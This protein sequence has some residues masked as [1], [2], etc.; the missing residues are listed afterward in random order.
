M[1]IDKVMKLSVFFKLKKNF[2]KLLFNVDKLFYL[3]HEILLTTK[4]NE[5][6]NIYHDSIRGKKCIEELSLNIG[7]WAGNYSFFYVLNRVLYDYKPKRIIELGLGESTKFISTYLDNYL[8]ESEHHIVEHDKEWVDFFNFNFPLSNKS[9]I[10]NCPIITK[11]IKGYQSH[12]YDDLETVIIGKYD[13]Y[14]V[15]GPFGSE[16]YSRYNII[17][18]VKTFVDGDDFIILMD[19]TN[20]KGENDTKNDII[21]I[22]KDKKINFYTGDYSG[23]KCVTVISSEKYRFSTTM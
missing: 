11:D 10:I 14:I 15:D 17:S 2:V 5:W 8:L 16:R 6:A 18:F 22:L 12:Y 7:R 13:L 4:E 19:D 9:Q 3:Q 21:S 1:E 23:N 20:R